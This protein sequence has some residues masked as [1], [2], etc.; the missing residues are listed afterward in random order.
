MENW[1]TFATVTGGAAAGLTGLLFVAVS[2]RINV[3]AKSQELRNRAA[4]TLTLFFTVLLIAI[5]LAIPDQSLQVLGAEL[6]ALAM[7]AAG[8]M[9]V[10][11]RR[12]RTGPTARDATAHAVASILDAVA[13][14]ALT[15]V[16]LLVAGLLLVF[17][18]RAGLDVLVLPVL[19]ALAGGV[20]SAWLL[21]TKIPSR[22]DT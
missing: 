7:I 8:G 3:I 1:S 21:L 15:S 6:I 16:L 20:T 17:G 4:Q 13:P 18:L 10:L 14:N 5:L 11:D 22:A 9:L 19:V 12:A 2:I